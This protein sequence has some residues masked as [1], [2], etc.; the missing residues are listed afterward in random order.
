MKEQE[1]IFLS[2]TEST[3][4]RKQCFEDKTFHESVS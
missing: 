2:V 1:K 3:L 4:H